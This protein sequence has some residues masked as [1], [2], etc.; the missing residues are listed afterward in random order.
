MG[1]SA[2]ELTFDEDV[3]DD[4]AIF[5]PAGYWHEV[6]NTG[7]DILQLYTIYAPSEHPAGTIHGTYE[8]ATN[9]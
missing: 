5:I 9:Y 6:S 3:S 8:D 2:D 1:K 4:W 7:T